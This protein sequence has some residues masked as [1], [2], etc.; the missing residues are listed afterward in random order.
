MFFVLGRHFVLFPELQAMEMHGVGLAAGAFVYRV[1][2]AYKQYIAFRV[3]QL[4]SRLIG[5]AG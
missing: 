3:F 2:R 5:I 1:G 4:S